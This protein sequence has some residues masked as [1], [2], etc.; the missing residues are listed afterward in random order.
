MYY[1]WGNIHPPFIFALVVSGQIEDWVNSDVFNYF[2]FNTTVG[3]F[4]MGRHCLQL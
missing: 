4:K 3:E 1:I 2:Y